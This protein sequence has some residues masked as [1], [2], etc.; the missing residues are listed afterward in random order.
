MS[1]K[2]R[3]ED[4]LVRRWGRGAAYEERTYTHRL[5]RQCLQSA[6]AHSARRDIAE[7]PEPSL[8]WVVGPFHWRLQKGELKPSGMLSWRQFSGL[9][10][11]T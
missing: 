4:E 2:R 8:A 5:T 9:W 6:R 10:Q 1:A 11:R 7:T 3:G